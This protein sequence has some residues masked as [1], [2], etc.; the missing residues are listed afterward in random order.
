VFRGFIRN[1]VGNLKLMMIVFLVPFLAMAQANTHCDGLSNSTNIRFQKKLV[2]VEK[3]LNEGRVQ[4]F[5]VG[6]WAKANSFD[7]KRLS[8]I[9]KRDDQ[10]LMKG[11]SKIQNEISARLKVDRVKFQSWIYQNSLQD[12]IEINA[13]PEDGSFILFKSNSFGISRVLCSAVKS[14]L[15]SVL[16]Y[17]LGY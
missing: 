8:A 13:L 1:K 10:S 2:Q 12:D 16:F 14:E 5:F 11:V 4:S 9:M 7:K 3:A 17:S 15:P 6:L